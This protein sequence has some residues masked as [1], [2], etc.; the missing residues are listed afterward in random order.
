[1]K[2]KQV[3]VV[4]TIL[5]ALSFGVSQAATIVAT[6]SGN[7]SSTTPNAPW[8]GGVVPLATD[9][10]TVNTPNNVTVDATAT[11]D[12]IA[13][14]GTVTMA[15]NATLN[16]SGATSGTGVSVATLNATATGNTVNYTGN[17]YFT[18]Y[19][20]YYNLIW[21]GYGGPYATTFLTVLNDFT[22]SGN[23]GGQADG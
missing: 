1:M 18:K 10:V 17:T 7:W 9:N 16:V 13:G 14:S 22:M 23:N 11:I 19:T 15:P 6:G 20:T 4:L 12:Y 21:S 5:F 2:T 8:P 3:L